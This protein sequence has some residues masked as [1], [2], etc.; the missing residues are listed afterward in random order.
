MS[1][2]RTSRPQWPLLTALA[3]GVAAIAVLGFVLADPLD[4]S[5]GGDQSQRYVEAVVGAPARVNPLFAPV[6]ETDADIASLVFSGLTRLGPDGTVLP[7]LAESWEISDDGLTYTFRLRRDVKWHTGAD[8]TADDAVFTYQLLADPDLPSDPTLSRLWQEVSCTAHDP[9]TLLCQLP[10]PFAP[11]LAYTTVGLLPKHVL[12]TATAA[13]IA[14]DPFNQRPTGTGPYRL[15]QLDQ[16]KAVLR[17]NPSY[18]GDRPNIGEIEVRFFPDTSTAAAALSRGE[19]HGLLLGPGAVQED[20]DLLTKSSGLRAYTAN[21]TRLAVLFLNNL[22]PPFDDKTLRQAVALSIDVDRITGDL[23]GGRAVRADSPVV[24]GTWAFNPQ[25]Q[26]RPYDRDRAK[27]LLEDAGWKAGDGDIRQKDDTELR[28]SLMTDQDPV[29]I[30]IAQE[31]ANQLAGVGIQVTVT[32]Q[33][34]SDLV[35]EFLAPHQYQAAIFGWDPGP[36]PDPYPAWHSSQVGPDGGNLAGYQNE[37]AD[38]I[39]EEAR[40][41]ADLDKRQALYYTF[42]QKF[43]EDIPSV[44]LYYP[45]FTYFV[46]DDV[47][48]VEQGTLFQTSSRFA[49]ITSWTFGRG[50]ELID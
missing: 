7:D 47:Q 48:N 23:L 11:F 50:A 29:R 30:A 9:Y 3:L 16:T 31:I 2:R 25:L 1:R 8:F 43:Q 28:I 44:L 14:D 35:K 20:F 39:M 37:D 19:V 46:S 18:Y 33:G 21:R 40:R 5:P 13:T 10:E 32:P 17:A 15:A 42:Q 12:E 26:P 4:S 24:P 27:E 34:S 6:N 22:Q 49:G 36:D 41:T 45:V 38:R